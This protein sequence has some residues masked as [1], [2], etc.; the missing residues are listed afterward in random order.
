[1]APLTS[2][3]LTRYA[4]HLTLSEVGVEGQ[5]RLKNA[6]VVIVGAG[7]LG[8]PAALYL[9]AVGVG[10]IGLVDFDAVEASNLQ[11]QI[12]H[13]TSQLGRSKLESA[14]ARLTDLNPGVV[15]EPIAARLTEANAADVLARFDLAID[16]T[17]NFPTRYLINDASVVLGKPFVYG[18]V[19]RFAGQVAV[20]GAAAGPC[21]RCLFPEP[22]AEGLIPNCAAAGV[23]GVLPG[24]IGTLQATEAIK[25]I[26]GIGEPLIGRLLLYDALAARFETMAIRRD[27]R[28]RCSGPRNAKAIEGVP[29][30]ATESTEISVDQL[31]RLTTG[32]SRSTIV[33]VRERWE[34]DLGAIPGARHIPLAELIG[35]LGEIEGG[36]EVVVVCQQ[37]SRSRLAQ[38]MLSAAGI[39]ARS[40]AG[41]ME[42]WQ[43][44]R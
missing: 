38:Q 33:D 4:R 36:V 40:L 14:T 37:G 22:P 12:L 3:E 19:D 43:Q 31:T 11:R 27:P 39:R 21:Y 1:V 7:G 34:W 32:P 24:V 30:P 29:T 28:C 23:L 8:S 2:A 20:F 41:G 15:V 44:G 35:R 17:D 16:G 26:L 25:W 10:R 6:A 9:A 5:T 42:A 13:G 18:S